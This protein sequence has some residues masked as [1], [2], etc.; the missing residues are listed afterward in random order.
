MAIDYRSINSLTMV[1]SFPLPRI[2]ELLL[3]VGRAKY[4][5]SFDASSGFYQIAMH[6]ES[7]EYTAFCTHSGQYQFTRMS[8]GLVNATETYQRVINIVLK[9]CFGFAS[10]FVDDI[11]TFS[12]DWNSH[13]QHID[14]VLDVVER[15]GMTL[16]YKKSNFGQ[17]YIRYLGFIIGQNEHK[18]DPE[19]LKAIEKLQFPKT[20]KQM[21]SLL[22]LMNYYRTYCDHMA[23]RV[24]P[25]NEMIR[26]NK[27]T[28]L[29]PTKVEIKAF[30]EIKRCLTT[31]PILQCPNYD[32]DFIIQ[33]DASLIAIGCA[34]SQEIDGLER[35]ISYGS[36]TLTE[37]QK[38]WT[39]TELEAYSLIFGLLKFDAM[40]YGRRI[41]LIT[42]HSAL[43]YIRDSK[44]TSPKLIRWSLALSRYNIVE[45][46][47]KAGIHN[48]N[49]D[50]LSRLIAEV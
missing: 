6:P 44:P 23:E 5:S 12:L 42:D 30:E 33:S 24:K 11:S 13:L 19:N 10:A 34:L 28:I 14:K 16:K 36:A 17:R 9:P 15:N 49:V 25:L 4:I 45:I 47:H 1:D 3:T 26:K 39:I 37:T 27:P 21:R 32:Y 48:T 35:P 50:S 7:K 41:I 46:R 2:N 8:F 40:I 29:I 20:K 18:P 43:Q 31:A 22:G 38:R